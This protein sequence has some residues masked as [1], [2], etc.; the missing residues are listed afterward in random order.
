MPGLD[1]V[2]STSTSVV[3]MREMP[4]SGTSQRSPS[5]IVCCINAT[6]VAQRGE[7]VG[8]GQQTEHEDA[9][10]PVRGLRAGREQEA[11]EVDDLV[12]VERLDAVDARVAPAG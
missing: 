12:V 11:Q 7:L 9:R 2:P 5:S 8:V 10:R 6:V 4:V 3:V 1:H